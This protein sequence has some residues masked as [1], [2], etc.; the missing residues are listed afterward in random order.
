MCGRMTLTRPRLEEVAEELGAGVDASAVE[1]YR[2]RWNLAPTDVAWILVAGEG[3]A[4][5]IVPAVW[6]VLPAKQLVI[7]VR[8]EHV[9]RGAFGSMR[10]CAVIADGFYEWR[11]VAHPPA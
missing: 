9:A 6:G 4:R 10:H 2:A 7:N 8:G 3:D 1:V 11:Q 5:T